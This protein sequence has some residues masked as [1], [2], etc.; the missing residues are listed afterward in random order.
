M[1]AIMNNPNAETENSD[2]FAFLRYEDHN[3]RCN[4]LEEAKQAWEKLTPAQK[5]HA[6]IVANGTMYN[7]AEIADM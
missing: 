6:S 3:H 1:E 2:D 7:Q 4:S 5:V